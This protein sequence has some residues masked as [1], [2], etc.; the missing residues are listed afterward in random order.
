MP[1]TLALHRYG[2]R[3]WLARIMLTWAITVLM[4]FTTSMPAFCGLRFVLGIAEA[5]FYPGVI[6]Y[7][8]LW[9]LQSYRAKVSASSRSAARSRTC[10]AR[11]SAACC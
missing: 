9:F 4:G 1:S 2:A 3:V 8:T 7:L 10:S 6:Y 11:W 5:G